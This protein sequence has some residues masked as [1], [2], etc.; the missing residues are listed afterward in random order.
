MI[1][2]KALMVLAFVVLGM[3]VLALYG[4]VITELFTPVPA[5]DIPPP[6]DGG[7]SGY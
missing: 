4:D 3:I 1:P 2:W 6:T 7:G 5:P